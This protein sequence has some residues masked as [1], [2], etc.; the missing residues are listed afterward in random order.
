VE[1][2]EDLRDSLDA[3]NMILFGSKAGLLS[4]EVK[5]CESWTRLICKGKGGGS[6]GLW[7]YRIILN[8]RA[9]GIGQKQSKSEISKHLEKLP[10]PGAK[11]LS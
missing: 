4:Y 6:K 8:K 2:H 1:E 5:E 9:N 11:G 10:L 7:K 3:T